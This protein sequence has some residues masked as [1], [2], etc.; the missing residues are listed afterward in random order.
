MNFRPLT[1]FSKISLSRG[2]GVED[3]V[4][5]TLFEKIRGGGG[6]AVSRFFL[7][8]ASIDIQ[9]EF[10]VL[11]TRRTCFGKPSIGHSAFGICLHRILDE[12]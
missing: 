10:Q 9:F 11:V 7:F 6:G 4:E 8:P 12:D 5:L 1:D 3:R 2:T